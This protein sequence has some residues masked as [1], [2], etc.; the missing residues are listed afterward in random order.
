M[1]TSNEEIIR[2]AKSYADV[3]GRHEP[4]GQD[5]MTAAVAAG[6]PADQVRSAAEIAM[7]VYLNAAPA[8]TEEGRRLRMESHAALV[9]TEAAEKRRNWAANKANAEFPGRANK[10]ARL[11]RIEDLLSK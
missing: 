10:A 8:E 7:H 1:N 9:A 6:V 5:W 3:G 2:I 4:N 11:A